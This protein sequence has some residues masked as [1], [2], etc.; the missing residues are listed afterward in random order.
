[1]LTLEAKLMVIF[2]RFSFNFKIFNVY[3]K[4]FN[5][6]NSF[7]LLQKMPILDGIS[8]GALMVFLP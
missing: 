1:M 4:L 2:Y 5:N 3:N 7:A 6:S 8:D